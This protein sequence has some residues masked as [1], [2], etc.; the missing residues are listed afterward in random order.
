MDLHL[1]WIALLLSTAEKRIQEAQADRRW[2]EAAWW[3]ALA[4]ALHRRAR[5]VRRYA[6]ANSA[7]AFSADST[8]FSSSDSD[9]P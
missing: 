7:S 5:R 8:P 1:A 2:E 4:K 3:S 9:T 6:L